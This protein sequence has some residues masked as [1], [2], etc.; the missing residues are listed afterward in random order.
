MRLREFFDDWRCF[1][2]M[3]HVE[4]RLSRKPYNRGES[5][6]ARIIREIQ[7]A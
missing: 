3:A 7:I 1:D 4:V 5:T 2:L 6:D